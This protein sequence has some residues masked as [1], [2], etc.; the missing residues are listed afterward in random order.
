MLGSWQED[1]E[2]EEGDKLYEGESERIHKNRRCKERD[3]VDEE[4][5]KDE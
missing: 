4:W 5:K 1:D 2:R 3:S